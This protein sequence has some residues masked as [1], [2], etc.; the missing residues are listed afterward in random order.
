LD[1]YFLN[2]KEEQQSP[3]PTQRK[4]REQQP[5][6]DEMDAPLQHQPSAAQLHLQKTIHE[7]ET[8]LK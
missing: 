4:M 5:L 6:E 8:S 7:F 2:D 1:D 3:E